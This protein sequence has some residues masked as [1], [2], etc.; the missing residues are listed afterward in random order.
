MT[1]D[2]SVGARVDEARCVNAWAL[3]D[4]VGNVGSETRNAPIAT[5]SA[6]TLTCHVNRSPRRIADIATTSTTLSWS[7]DTTRGARQNSPQCGSG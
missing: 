1:G 6:P 4:D 3:Y 7:A 5:R 2:Y